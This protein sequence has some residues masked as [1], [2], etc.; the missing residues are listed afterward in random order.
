MQT[1]IENGT[2]GNGNNKRVRRPKNEAAQTAP[3]QETVAQEAAPAKERKPRSDKGV[4]RK[5]KGEVVIEGMVMQGAKG[6]DINSKQASSKLA[7][8]LEEADK[9]DD[10][11]NGT[12]E[13]PRKPR[14]PKAEAATTGTAAGDAAEQ[15]IQQ[16]MNA[17]NNG[18]EPRK[19]RKERSDKGVPRKH[20]AEEAQAAPQ[21]APANNVQA[22]PAEPKKER[23]VRSDKGVPRKHKAEEAQAAPQQAAPA[24]PKARGRRP[25]WETQMKHMEAAPAAAEAAPATPKRGRKAVEAAPVVP[26]TPKKE[27]APYGSRL[28]KD[29]PKVAQIMQEIKQSD[30]ALIKAVDI[31]FKVNAKGEQGAG[32]AAPHRKVMVDIAQD[33]YT[34][35]RLNDQQKAWLRAS[36]KLSGRDRLGIYWKQLAAN[37]DSWQVG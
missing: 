18:E 2:N 26:A 30:R 21:E 11:K 22:S 28:K 20:K 12:T 16:M 24:K 34:N 35:G 31:L 33:L 8:A 15:Q 6:L 13:L 27:R 32:F 3:V 36:T 23:K 9:A 10:A 29:S 19:P 25:A 1:Q 17:A 37:W 7:Q 14:K 4:P 5:P